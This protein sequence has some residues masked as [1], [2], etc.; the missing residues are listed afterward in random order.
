MIQYSVIILCAGSGTRTG[1]KYNKM[2]YKLENQTIYEKTLSVF[3]ND[4]RCKQIIVVCK[5]SEIDDFKILSKDK[6]IQYC[7]GGKERQDSV[8]NGLQL[9]SSEHVLIHDGARPYIEKKV[10]D[11]ICQC[12]CRHNACLVMVPSK[13]TIKEVVDGKVVN[14]PNREQ[15]MQAQTPQAF[16]T[17]LILSAYQKGK[18]MQF[19][20][21]DD[22]SLVENFEQEEVY[23][24]LG[25]YTNKKITTIEDLS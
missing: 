19:V 8:Y 11:D 13:D 5:K 18:E 7:I 21:T 3:I 4:I 10:I 14:T 25:S 12:L 1:L 6:R 22:A 9:V 2:F 23:V 15:M 20:A 16:L 24:V 17:K